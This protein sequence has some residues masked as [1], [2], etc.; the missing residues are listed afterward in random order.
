MPLIH[1]AEPL[2]W[3]FLC[4]VSR[5]RDIVS[6]R[7]VCIKI[8]RRQRSYGIQTRHNIRFVCSAAHECHD[9]DDDDDHDDGGR[10]TE[11]AAVAT[12]SGERNPNRCDCVRGARACVGV[13]VTLSLA[14]PGGGVH[15]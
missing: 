5:A 7:N 1:L 11:T 15:L 13:V 6:P 9:N 4:V 14:V 3:R 12:T 2:V 8:R 10:A